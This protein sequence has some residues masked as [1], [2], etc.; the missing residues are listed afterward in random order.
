MSGYIQPRGKDEDGK[1]MFRV[2]VSGGTNEKTGKRIRKTVV[3]HGSM[4]EAEQVKKQLERELENQGPAPPSRFEEWVER[5]LKDADKTRA[6]RTMAEYRRMLTTR[7]LPALGHIRLD[8]LRSRHI[9]EFMTKLAGVKHARNTEETITKHSQ[10]KYYCLL[11]VIFQDAV[12]SGLLNNNPVRQVKAPRI[13]SYRARFYEPQDVERLWLALQ[14]EPLMWRA[15]IATGLLLGIRRGE[16]LGLRWSDINWERKS[17]CIERAAYR[18]SRD[19]QQVKVPKTASS[20]RSIPMPEPLAVILNAWLS[21]QGGTAEDYICSESRGKWLHVDAPTKWFAKFIARHQLPSLNLHGLRHTAAT[22]M[23]E[24]GIPVRTVSEHLGHGQT[25][26]TTNIYAHTTQ[27]SRELAA[28]ALKKAV[29]SGEQ[30]E[31]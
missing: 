27:N 11:S 15:I 19:K 12:Y 29:T 31:K 10:R 28:E 23:L 7:I 14:T 2:F 26:T 4:R 25:S 13:E 18:V 16:L 30:N 3:V 21:E 9:Y 17:I 20:R 22:I 8:Q 6:P 5:W 1:G 24:A